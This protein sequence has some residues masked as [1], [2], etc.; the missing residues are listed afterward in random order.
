MPS[1]L[2][3]SLFFV[4][5]VLRLEFEAFQSLRYSACHL[6]VWL[7]APQYSE[8][9]GRTEVFFHR[10]SEEILIFRRIFLP[11]NCRDSSRTNK[12]TNVNLF[13]FLI[14]VSSVA[15]TRPITVSVWRRK[16]ADTTG[17]NTLGVSHPQFLARKSWKVPHLKPFRFAR[18]E[19]YSS[20]P[21]LA[22]NRQN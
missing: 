12:D 18:N 17:L 15:P 3:S 20:L 21:L 8:A 14:W 9:Q 1:Y 22:K 7:S 16:C 11:F 13:P 4:G 5:H 6:A 19:L 2:V 10:H